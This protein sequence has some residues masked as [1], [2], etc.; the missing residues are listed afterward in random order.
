MTMRQAS[1]GACCAGATS[2]ACSPES[3]QTI[4]LP[5][6][7]SARASASAG[8]P[9][10]RRRLISRQRSSFCRF[11]AS[12]MKAMYIGLP[13][14]LLPNSTRRMRSLA[15]ASFWKVA[16]NLRG[17]GELII[18]TRGKAEMLARRGH[19]RPQH[20]GGPYEEPRKFAVH[21]NLN[22]SSV[23]CMIEDGHA[24]PAPRSDAPTST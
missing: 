11:A 21:G 3:I 7:A 13:S 8:C 22:G 12:E 14:E 6:S 18:V 20:E 5:S 24:A 16:K 23:C 15:A 9:S 19:S 4:A 1:S 2:L 17:V 10:A